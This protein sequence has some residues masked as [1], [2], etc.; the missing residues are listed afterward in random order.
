[1]D[2]DLE[3]LIAK[4]VA[5]L[6]EAQGALATAKSQLSGES[7]QIYQLGETLRE[8]EAAARAMR[9][10]LDYMERNPESVLKGKKQ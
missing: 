5:T 9:E 7:V 4:T 10:F 2:T 8:V 1:M 6:D 3:P